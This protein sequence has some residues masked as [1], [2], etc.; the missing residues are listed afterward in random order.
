MTQEKTLYI[1]TTNSPHGE[2]RYS[3][4]E[5]LESAILAATQFI[6]DHY[7]NGY[8]T[9]TVEYQGE[10]IRRGEWGMS[11]KAMLREVQAIR[12]RIE[13]I[14]RVVRNNPKW[15]ERLTLHLHYRIDSNS[16]YTG[17][18]IT[19]SPHV[20]VDYHGDVV[21][22]WGNR[23]KAL[24]LSELTKKDIHDWGEGMFDSLPSKHQ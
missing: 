6:T 23:Q 14:A 18:E 13:R 4:A 7:P 22:T 21:G 12:D 11:D 16:N 19:I 15:A 17:V 5:S 10:V 3:T 2:R 9:Y 24:S 1:W 8:G 20:R